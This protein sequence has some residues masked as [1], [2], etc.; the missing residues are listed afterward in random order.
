MDG[1]AGAPMSRL[2]TLAI[3]GPLG[4]AQLACLRSWRRLGCRTV[5]LHLD[6]K[7]LNERFRRI[8]SVYSYVGKFEGLD[9]ALGNQI[10]KTLRDENVVAINALSENVV[11]QLW[12]ARPLLPDEI[13][14]LVNTPSLLDELESKLFQIEVARRAGFNVLPTWILNKNTHPRDW[15]TAFPLV[16]RPDRASK[17]DPP[18]KAE[19]IHSPEELKTF[20]FSQKAAS[21]AIVAQPFIRGPNLLIH[22]YRSQDGSVSGRHVAYHIGVKY[23]GVSVTMRPTRLD[24]ELDRCCRVFEAELS[25]Q[26]V[27]HLDLL[28]DHATGAA[29]FLEVN[30]RL[31]GTTGKAYA[32][33]YDEP[34]KLLMA[35]GLIGPQPENV[36]LRP[37]TKRIAAIRCLISA[38]LGRSSGV[39][40]PYPDH[41]K[42]LRELLPAMAT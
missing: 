28:L 25:L 15:P 1:I 20:L 5:F 8:A 38:L 18:F 17:V 24:P 22:G 33:G 34:V 39:D 12:R 19:I 32:S 35:F 16:L 13:T 23:N 36:L 41:G 31:G 4:S 30:G 21:A 27:F 2:P 29:W 40:Y 3:L 10:A 37:A 9:D 42:L 6:E 11:A 14:L 26:G 7:P